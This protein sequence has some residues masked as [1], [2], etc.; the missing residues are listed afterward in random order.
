LEELAIPINRWKAVLDKLEVTGKLKPVKEKALR[1]YEETYQFLLPKSYRDF[2]KV[3]GAGF[4]TRPTNYEI[5]VPGA[6]EFRYTL[7]PN[8][9]GNPELEPDGWDPES[10]IRFKRGWVFASD[11]APNVYFWDPHEHTLSQD[12]EYAIY[13]IEHEE[14][15]VERLAGTF[16][17]FVNEICLRPTTNFELTFRPAV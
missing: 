12:N 13:G 16:W 15:K 17:E 8:V 1:E 7:C 9:Y 14:L 10:F 5:Q 2:C 6:K 4:L 3:F 11:I